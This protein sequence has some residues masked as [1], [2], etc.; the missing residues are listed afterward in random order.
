MIMHNLIPALIF[1]YGD[2]MKTYFFP[3]AVEAAKND[4]WDDT[5]K[6]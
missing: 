4:Y 6:D 5:I 3:E 2:N 1:K